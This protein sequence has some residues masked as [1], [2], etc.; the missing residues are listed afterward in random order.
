MVLLGMAPVMV[1]LKQLIHL[2]D[3]SAIIFSEQIKKLNV[4]AT[5]IHVLI[6][7]Y[8]YVHTI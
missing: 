5:C 4:T 3:H 2:N 1:L 6:P 8:L 7:P